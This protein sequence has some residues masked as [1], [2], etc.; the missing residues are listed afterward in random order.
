M[1]NR[2]TLKAPYQAGVLD[3]H[4]WDHHPQLYTRAE[5]LVKCN[6]PCSYAG[7]RQ[8]PKHTLHFY[9]LL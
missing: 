7:G 5:E 6:S 3:K 1:T 2:P 9:I 8:N 4:W